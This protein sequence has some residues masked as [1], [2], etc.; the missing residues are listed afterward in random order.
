MLQVRRA[1]Q[2]FGGDPSARR[3]L[4]KERARLLKALRASEASMQGSH[5]RYVPSGR[6]SLQ[7]CH[8]VQI[9]QPPTYVVHQ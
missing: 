1:I 6:G 9:G 3:K 2:R 7:A 8:Q 4:V 5:V